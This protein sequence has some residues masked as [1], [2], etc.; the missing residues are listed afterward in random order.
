M[1]RGLGTLHTKGV[2]QT[3]VMLLRCRKEGQSPERWPRAVCDGL[4]KAF[5]AS[6]ETAS[7]ALHPKHR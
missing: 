4:C 6:D 7:K 1:H 2:L 5:L 3:L